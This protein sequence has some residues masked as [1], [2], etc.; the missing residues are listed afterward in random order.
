MTRPNS[1]AA[2]AAEHGITRGND[3]AEVLNTDLTDLSD[4]KDEAIEAALRAA[5]WADRFTVEM[6]RA[7]PDGYSADILLARAIQAHYPDMIVD[8]VT[9]KVREIVAAEWPD[10]S[11]DQMPR[12]TGAV[13]AGILAG[14]AMRG[15]G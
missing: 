7:A 15:E 3:M 6:V 9:R 4:V 1:D 14:M 10:F 12:I 13:K 5:G 8:P 11:T 2:W